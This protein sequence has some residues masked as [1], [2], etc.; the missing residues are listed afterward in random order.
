MPYDVQRGENDSETKAWFKA[1]EKARK[2]E[3]VKEVAVVDEEG[4]E[5]KFPD[6]V[7]AA[8]SRCNSSRQ[9]QA[10][11]NHTLSNTR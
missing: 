11:E 5:V 9:C 1:I 4:V 6:A 10:I 7:H 8:N 3:I 2:D